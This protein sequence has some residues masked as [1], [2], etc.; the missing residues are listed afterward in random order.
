MT[1]DLTAMPQAPDI[2]R[3]VL[4]AMLFDAEAID[5]ASEALTPDSF[6]R[7]ENMIIFEAIR[8]MRLSG[9]NIDFLTLCDELRKRGL[10]ERIGGE[11][12]V[13]AIS[14]EI[15]SYNTAAHCDI[16]NNRLARRKL[17]ALSASVR[18][19][20]Q[21]D[22]CDPEFVASEMYMQSVAIMDGTKE[23]EYT[24]MSSL[25]HEAHEW[26]IQKSSSTGTMGIP[27]G[28]KSLDR[29]IDG[30]QNGNLY[31]LAGKTGQGKSALAENSFALEAALHGVP[32]AIF[33]LEMN[34]VQICVRMLA[35]NAKMD[36]SDIQYQK[37][38]QN[39]WDRIGETCSR[40]S[41][42]PLYIDDTPGIQIN[43]LGAKIR[44]LQ[45]D[46]GVK[47]VIVD[48][49]Q[50]MEGKRTNSREQEVASISRGL[51]LLAKSL[52]IPIVALSQFSR[53]ADHD[54]KARPQP[55]WL[56]ES[57]AIEQDA[58]GI[59]FIWNATDEQKKD[60]TDIDKPENVREIIIGK[61]RGGKVGIVLTRWTP[62]HTR[63]NDLAEE[64]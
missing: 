55:S 52:N 33:S 47:L 42:I 49:L 14:S 23:A 11:P 44:R 62:E 64:R 39:E 3:A 2:E 34:A 38:T 41:Q 15:V 43:Q 20:C 36:L 13:A 12:T 31:I 29:Y 8:D 32:T 26:L 61:N 1:T 4:S 10:L 59:L 28:L 40:L 21:E 22:S 56:R 58:D 24:S 17:I 57:G 60:Y 54:E 45:R 16:L 19:M 30:W 18:A 50:L 27:T 5:I 37:P 53:K 9:G 25:V 51:K 46:K 35:S 48:Y 7:T 63:F 6:Y